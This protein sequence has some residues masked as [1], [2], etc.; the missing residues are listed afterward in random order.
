MEL[1]NSNLRENLQNTLNDLNKILEYCGNN[2][3]VCEILDDDTGSEIG[4]Y[5]SFRIRKLHTTI[6]L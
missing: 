3:I 4:E 6:N 5:S 2:E 1:N